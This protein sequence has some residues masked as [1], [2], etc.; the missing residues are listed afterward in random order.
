M[1]SVHKSVLV[2]YSVI[3][4]SVV[5]AL[6]D[7]ATEIVVDVPPQS[8]VGDALDRS[9]IAAR[10]PEFDFAAC[11]VGIF[12]RNVDRDHVLVQGD[13]IEVYRPLLADPKESRRKRARPP[14]G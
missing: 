4:V 13:R 10:H 11:A 5:Y 2:P 6:P 9:R 14:R 7:A 8:T 3:T 12:G 1:A